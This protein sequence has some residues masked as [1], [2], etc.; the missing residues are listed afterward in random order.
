MFAR[1]RRKFYKIKQ[2]VW[3]W[4]WAYAT[5]GAITALLAVLASHFI[6]VG[7]SYKGFG[8]EAVSTILSILAS[9]MLAVTTFSLSIMV[10]AFGSASNG[11]TPRSTS[12]LMGDA[13]TQN[14]LSTFLGAFVFS[15]VGIIGLQSSIYGP[16]GRL[17]LFWVTL[18]VLVA[19]LWQLVRWINHLSHFGRL[20]DTV[21]R[22][23]VAAQEAIDQWN[24]QPLL[25][26]K[27]VP[28]SFSAPLVATITPIQI[29]YIEHIEIASI[30]RIAIEN[31][32]EVHVLDLPGGFVHPK[33]AVMNIYGKEK[34][35]EDILAQLV[36]CVDIARV[37]TF[38]Q[39]PRFGIVTLA[40]IAARALSPATNDSGTAIDIIGR[41]VRVLS[42]FAPKGSKEPIY[43]MVYVDDL[44]MDDVMEDAFLSTIRDAGGLIEVHLRIQ[45]TLL[46]LTELAPDQFKRSAVYY[47]NRSLAVCEQEMSNQDDILRVRKL[48]EKIKQ[49][50]ENSNS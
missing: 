4:V 22:V 37:R 39:D 32:F 27:P 20:G 31:D 1:L 23:E 47:S 11:A 16:A 17:V 28:N 38:E 46:S 6:D 49:A 48:Y 24:N 50:A 30:D 29:G 34:P 9:S 41:Y 7:E 18:L 40:E 2:R 14:V 12:L 45:K 21:N 19:V 35:S 26:G 43:K 8:S 42:S 5:L 36:Q 15:I 33:T 10:Q 3:F 44:S 13:T 25:G